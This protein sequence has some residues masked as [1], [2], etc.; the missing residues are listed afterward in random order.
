MFVYYTI[1]CKDERFYNSYIC[2]FTFSV[3]KHQWIYVV[4]VSLIQVEETEKEIRKYMNI[5]I[6]GKDT[7]FLRF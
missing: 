2:V 5:N 7:I 6:F 1:S 3:K 4:K